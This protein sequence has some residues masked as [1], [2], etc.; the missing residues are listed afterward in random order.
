MLPETISEPGGE[1]CF[2]PEVKM[3]S[4]SLLSLTLLRKQTAKWLT[5]N[6]DLL[7][8]VNEIAHKTIFQTDESVDGVVG[9]FNGFRIYRVKDI[10][11]NQASQALEEVISLCFLHTNYSFR[12]MQYGS[13]RTDVNI[14]GRCLRASMYDLDPVTGYAEVCVEI[15]AK[16]EFWNE[17]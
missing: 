8:Y 15:N 10:K 12:V 2:V 11:V 13:I 3:S 4:R 5:G 7:I 14:H 6:R 9:V 17:F 16:E 1:D